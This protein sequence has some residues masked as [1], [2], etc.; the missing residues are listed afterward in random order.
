MASGAW[1]RSRRFSREVGDTWALLQAV[2]GFYILAL[3]EGDAG[4]GDAGGGG[5]QALPRSRLG[6]RRAAPS[7]S[8]VHSGTVLM[9]EAVFFRRSRQLVQVPFQLRR[10]SCWNG[11]D[12][13]PP[14]EAFIRRGLLKR[15]GMSF[16][17]NAK[18][19]C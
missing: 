17:R 3:L 7:S 8:I 2:D 13:V 5:A 15:S 18:I 10:I 9:D 19:F 16:V 1:L 11:L 6:S 4:R 12:I 14:R